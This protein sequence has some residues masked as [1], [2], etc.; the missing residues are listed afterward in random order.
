MPHFKNFDRSNKNK[1][2]N[3][4]LGLIFE[5][6]KYDS[7]KKLAEILENNKSI[8]STSNLKEA[9]N[10][11]KFDAIYKDIQN[12]LSA[13]TNKEFLNLINGCY[14]KEYTKI[15]NC[16]A[17]YILGINDV[18]SNNTDVIT[19][20]DYTGLNEKAIENIR[21]IIFYSDKYK[22]TDTSQILSNIL[23]SKSLNDVLFEIE[24][25]KFILAR[26]KEKFGEIEKKYNALDSNTIQVVEELMDIPSDKE[27]ILSDKEKELIDKKPSNFNEI[28][29]TINDYNN[30]CYH[31]D[32]E[33]KDYLKYKKYEILKKFE[34]LIDELL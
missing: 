31:Y 12:Q 4:L 21:K 3:R 32:T 16:S 18:I 23:S 22:L 24:Q 1:L 2:N 33:L 15:F 20:C 6:N 13:S 10:T 19:S 25:Y 17:N 34:E 26:E 11:K 8:Y 29:K 14:I 27:Y 30:A 7:P 28:A 5:R 9:K